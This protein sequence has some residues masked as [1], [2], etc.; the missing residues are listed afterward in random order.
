MLFRNLKTTIYSLIFFSIFL[1]VGPLFAPP[2][3]CEDVQVDRRRVVCKS[4]YDPGV[5]G[6]DFKYFKQRG[7][8]QT[9]ALGKLGELYARDTIERDTKYI[10]IVT[11][12]RKMGCNV[13]N[14]IHDGADRGIDDIFVVATADGRIN[15]NHNPIFHEAKF[16][17]NCSL[18][19]RKTTTICQ[20]LS[21]QWL[22]YHVKGAQKRAIAGARLCFNDKNTL[23]VMPC[24]TCKTTFI[25]DMDWLFDMLNEQRFHRT[26][27][28]LCPNGQLKVYKVISKE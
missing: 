17:G 4:N 26:A 3:D 10:S 7:L 16:D 18:K 28:V 23:T 20:Q 22:T 25:N 1:Q 2:S 19:L 9:K 6:E 8:S 15:R 13:E 11:L 21:K 27:S 24:Q 14:D 12:F 5:L